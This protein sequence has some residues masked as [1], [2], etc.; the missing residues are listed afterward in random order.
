MSSDVSR[1]RCRARRGAG[2]VERGSLE[3]CCALRGAPWVQIPPP[4]LIQAESGPLA[5]DSERAFSPR[6][7]DR[8]FARTRSDT[9]VSESD[10][11]SSSHLA[12]ALVTATELRADRFWPGVVGQS[13]KPLEDLASCSEVVEVGT[14]PNCA[15][16]D[17]IAMTPVLSGDCIERADVLWSGS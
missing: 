16:Q 4:P 3:N 15:R 1:V 11:H 7:Q 10:S 8:S 12:R 6:S 9:L 2:A 5:G 13:A 14:P 17:G